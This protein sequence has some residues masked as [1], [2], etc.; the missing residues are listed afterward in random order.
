MADNNEYYYLYNN[1]T[2]GEEIFKLKF[3]NNGDY[4]IDCSNSTIEIVW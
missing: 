1:Q 4:E 3:L 2:T